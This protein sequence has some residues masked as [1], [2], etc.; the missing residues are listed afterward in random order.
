MTSGLL[1]IQCVLYGIAIIACI[2]EFSNCYGFLRNVAAICVIVNII[3]SFCFSWSVLTAFLAIVSVLFL[4]ALFLGNDTLFIITIIIGIIFLIFSIC[5]GI[6]MRTTDEISRVETSVIEI[7]SIGDKGISDTT[8]TGSSNLLF[9]SV[10]GTTEL[11]YYYGYYYKDE[12]GALKIGTIPAS[13]T[14]LFSTLET[15][16]YINVIKTY[17]KNVWFMTEIPAK[18]DSLVSTRYE[19]YVPADAIPAD[20]SFDLN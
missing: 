5:F 13:K 9:G 19:L 7:Y 20:F 17:N 18:E 11:T 12:N 15:G 8:I 16:A 6:G 10:T 1:I 4:L 3:L 14:D 2:V